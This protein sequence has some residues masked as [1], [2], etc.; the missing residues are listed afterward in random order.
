MQRFLY[1]KNGLVT[2]IVG[3]QDGIAP[4][5]LSL[6][7]ESIVLD[8]TGTTSVGDAFDPKPAQGSTII[9]A[10]DSVVLG[11]LF[12]LSNIVAI[13]QLKPTQTMAQYQADLVSQY[14]PTPK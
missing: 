7:G 13:L 14:A 8:P 4:P 6:N 10:M 11:E 5:L 9:A 1:V 3:Y 12:R 2:N